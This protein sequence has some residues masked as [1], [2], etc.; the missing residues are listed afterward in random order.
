MVIPI[1]HPGA[2]AHW[3]DM[4][5]WGIAVAGYAL[6][7]VYNVILNKYEEGP[8]FY[9]NLEYTVVNAF[10]ALGARI[11]TALI[12]AWS[13]SRECVPTER[14]RE[15]LQELWQIVRQGG[16]YGMGPPPAGENNVRRRLGR[17]NQRAGIG[18]DICPV[19]GLYPNVPG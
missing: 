18:S 6:L 8:S 14:L 1:G 13:A 3:P 4:A 17:F 19:P 16:L 5:N 11:V 15:L 12:A 7:T 2:T 10:L 9:K